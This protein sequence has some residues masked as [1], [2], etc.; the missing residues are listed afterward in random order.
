MRLIGFFTLRKKSKDLKARKVKKKGE[1]AQEP[2]AEMHH[3][4]GERKISEKLL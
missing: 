4:K 2:K 1:G 3:H